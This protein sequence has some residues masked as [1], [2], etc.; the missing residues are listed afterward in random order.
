MPSGLSLGGWKFE[1]VRGETGSL[2]LGSI[3]GLNAEETSLPHQVVYAK[4]SKSSCG[5]TGRLSDMVRHDQL[6]CPTGRAPDAEST[7]ASGGRW[8][9]S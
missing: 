5:I 1:A 8:I 3:G 9:K 7:E 4:R 2:N 6:S